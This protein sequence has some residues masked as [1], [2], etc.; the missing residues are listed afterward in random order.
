MKLD[1]ISVDPNSSIYFKWMRNINLDD[2][3]LNT[4]PRGYTN[5]TSHSYF[6]GYNYTTEEWVDTTLLTK[7]KLPAIVSPS[8]ALIDNRYL[9]LMN[10]YIYPNL[11]T[12]SELQHFYYEKATMNL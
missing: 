4:V 8:V 10:G 9:L 1:M 6:K 12:Y 3:K 2:M 7:R 5:V 11:T